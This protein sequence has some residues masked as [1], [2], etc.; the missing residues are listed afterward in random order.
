MVRDIRIK[1]Y[2]FPQADGNETFPSVWTDHAINGELLRVVATANFTGSIILTESGTGITFCNFTVTS[3][4]NLS[5]N[6]NFTVTTGSFTTNTLLNMQI[7]SLESGTG[8]VY[9]PVSVLYR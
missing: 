5:Q 3:G 2:R 1:E 4:T 9:G 8:V 6:E 7:G